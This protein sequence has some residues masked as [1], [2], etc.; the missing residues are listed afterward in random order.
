VLSTVSDRK[1][2]VA[3]AGGLIA[4]WQPELRT[5]TDY[6]PYGMQMAGRGFASNAYRWGFQ[7]QE[8]DCETGWVNYKY[9]MHD[10]RTGRFSAVD[11]LAGEYP[12]Y[13]S[14]AFSGNRLL[15]AVELEGLEPKVASETKSQTILEDD[16]KSYRIGGGDFG[17]SLDKN[18]SVYSI[19]TPEGKMFNWNEDIQEYTEQSIYDNAEVFGS[20]KPDYDFYIS[21]F[22]DVDIGDG[23]FWQKL[24]RTGDAWVNG[25]GPFSGPESFTGEEFGRSFVNNVIPGVS[26]L[27]SVLNT[28]SKLM[29]GKDIYGDSADL[30]IVDFM[31]PTA[32]AALNGVKGPVGIVAKNVLS[33]VGFYLDFKKYTSPTKE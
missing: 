16:K 6:Y 26:T 32:D 14:Y 29:T 3:G 31:L 7:G 21:S 22:K 10:P 33:I 15:D 4:Y 8:E 25:E 30:E 11:P 5:A 20:S 1:R 19:S 12:Y 28:S 13:S 27:I 23:A 17:F 9:R 2:A 18:G 24:M